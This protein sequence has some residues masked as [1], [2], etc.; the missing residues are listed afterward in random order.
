MASRILSF[1]LIVVLVC[2]AI[3]VGCGQSRSKTFIFS[4]R[5]K[6]GWLGVEVQDV[7]RRLKEKKSLTVDEGAYV[8][9]VIEDSPAE[10]AGIQEGDVIVK[11]DSKDIDDSDDLTRTVHR[12]KPKTD[13]KVEVVRKSEHKTL[14][15]TIGR[16]S[17]PKAY[18][19]NFNDRMT[20]KVPS[21]PFHMHM[22][23]VNEMYGLEVQSLTKQLGE[24]FD[25]PDGKGVLVAEVEK[26]SDA[27]KAGFKAGDVI[28]RVNK[29]TIR[30][31]DDLREELSDNEGK[32]T[33]FDVIRKGTSV[34]LTMRLEDQDNDEEDDDDFSYNAF[35]PYDHSKI[36]AFRL[37]IPR[38]HES[39]VNRLKEGLRE[40]RNKL[41]E[42]I[43]ELK[44]SIREELV[45]S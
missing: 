26:G 30:D 38:W 39:E 32:E 9:D 23:S 42:K 28:T 35:V 4:D 27:D 17:A 10:K 14:S 45:N 33:P 8:T 29:N 41:K 1:F 2:A 11:F 21:T 36:K 5:N 34:T 40:F 20:P 25:V 3:T 16:S 18:S 15:A 13:V 19:F 7:T 37:E 22:F 12:T 24:Y 44:E 31:L 43:Q 6:Q